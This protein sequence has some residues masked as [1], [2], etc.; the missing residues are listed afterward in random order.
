V[1]WYQSLKISLS[2]HMANIIYESDVIFHPHR[3]WIH[4]SETLKFRISPTYRLPTLSYTSEKLPHQRGVTTPRYYLTSDPQILRTASSLS[5]HNTFIIVERIKR[6]T[7]EESGLIFSFLCSF[8]TGSDIHPAF[9]LKV[10]TT[11]FTET[12][13]LGIKADHSSPSSTKF[14]NI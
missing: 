13:L 12:N 6:W 9:H 1:Y 3:R 11:V 5:L 10:L 7:T 2:V 4:E 14:K 8:Q